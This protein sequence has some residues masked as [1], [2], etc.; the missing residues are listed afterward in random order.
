VSALIEA[1]A[2]ESQNSRRMDGAPDHRKVIGQRLFLLR[3]ACG[4]GE[5]Q[6]GFAKFVGITP[7]AWANYE[8]G[9]RRPNID[10]L[11]KIRAKTGATY[12][13]ILNGEMG[14]LRL[15]LAERLRIAE[16]E[17]GGSTRQRRA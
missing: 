13:Y 16:Q 12:E 2:P 5:N 3:A 14:G 4:Y 17:L 6:S 10:Q 11:A 8:A 1:S 15:D 7:P 9:D